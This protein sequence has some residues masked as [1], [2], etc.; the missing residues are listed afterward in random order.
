[1]NVKTFYQRVREIEQTLIDAVVVIASRETPDG[2]KEGVLIEV[3]RHLAATMIAD[4]RAF[5]ASPEAANLFYRRRQEE[6][7]AAHKGDITG[8]IDLTRFTDKTK[9]MGSAVTK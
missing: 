6:I 4:G 3:S 9:E 7:R 8:S 2:G 5:L 1:M